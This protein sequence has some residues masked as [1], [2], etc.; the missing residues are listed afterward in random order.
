MLDCFKLTNLKWVVLDRSL[1]GISESSGLKH[2]RSKLKLLGWTRSS[3]YRVTSD[4]WVFVWE[5]KYWGLRTINI[6]ILSKE[7]VCLCVSGWIPQFSDFLALLRYPCNSIRLMNGVT[8]ISR[9]LQTV[10]MLQTVC[11]LA[12]AGAPAPPS[13]PLCPSPALEV[14]SRTPVMTS[15][16]IS[17]KIVQ[18][19]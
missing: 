3:R 12:A 15:I 14:T 8:V 11:P 2:R 7:G 17:T 9:Q 13:W 19:K 5:M 16:W 4:R 6:V 10:S 1:L 18:S